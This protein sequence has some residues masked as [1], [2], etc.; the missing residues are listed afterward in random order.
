MHW[1]A[2]AE[3]GNTLGGALQVKEEVG[4]A[5]AWWRHGMAFDEGMASRLAACEVA[6]KVV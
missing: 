2:G 4:D 5:L 6:E 1:A 3:L